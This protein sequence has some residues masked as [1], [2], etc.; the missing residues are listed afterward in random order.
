MTKV[1]IAGA[2]A[3]VLAACT[4]DGMPIK[5]TAGALGGGA[6]VVSSVP[7]SARATA[8]YSP[9]PAAR[10]SAPFSVLNWASRWTAPTPWPSV[11]RPTRPMPRRSARP[12]VGTPRRAVTRAPSLRCAKAA[13]RPAAIAA[14]FS[15][16]SQLAAARNRR[17]VRPVSRPMDPGRSSADPIQ[18]REGQ[19][20]L[21]HPPWAALVRGGRYELDGHVG[22]GQ[23]L[24]VTR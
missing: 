13:P 15:R 12:S 10:C 7:S 5:Q 24:A 11:K 18:P 19:L 16:R 9:P 20:R 22:S 8:S 21:G 6:P 14:S 3:L 2:A 1:L 4:T 23:R 17:P